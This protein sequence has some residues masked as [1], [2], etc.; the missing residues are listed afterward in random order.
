MLH[1]CFCNY[2]KKWCYRRTF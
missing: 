2:F 1:I